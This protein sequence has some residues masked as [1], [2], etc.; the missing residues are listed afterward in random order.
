MAFLK[1]EVMRPPTGLPSYFAAQH[2]KD[3]LD[4]DLISDRLKPQSHERLP[5]VNN[6]SAIAERDGWSKLLMRV[7]TDL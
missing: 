5:Q 4:E 6:S 7:G 2:F 1:D 3:N